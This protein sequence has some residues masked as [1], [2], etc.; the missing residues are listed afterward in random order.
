[1]SISSEDFRTPLHSNDIEEP[2]D[3]E[4]WGETGSVMRATSMALAP[5]PE[6]TP[7][8]PLDSWN[9]NPESPLINR[10]PSEKLTVLQLETNL[11]LVPVVVLSTAALIY[12]QLYRRE[13]QTNNHITAIWFTVVLWF[14]LLSTS[15]CMLL[16]LC[17][18]DS[19]RL[20]FSRTVSTS[21]FVA[22][23]RLCANVLYAIVVLV[24]ITFDNDVDQTI[25]IFV[26]V[27][28]LADSVSALR[29]EV[30]GACALS[31]YVLGSADFVR[32]LFG[33]LL[34]EALRILYK[35][36]SP[37]SWAAAGL[38][39]MSVCCTYARCSRRGNL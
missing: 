5:V 22:L 28:L 15:A 17:V 25:C 4:M 39:L 10:T 1:M 35:D 24:V 14:Y 16:A 8:S 38:V 3:L 34:P 11:A 32:V 6:P 27:Y 23:F 37:V 2:Q 9:A 7:K 21:R 18:K 31:E 19:A 13:C 29:N 30:L 12:G 26:L 20:Q 36:G 33:F